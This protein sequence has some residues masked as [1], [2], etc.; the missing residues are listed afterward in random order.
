M[1]L[2]VGHIG[3][4]KEQPLAGSVLERWL[5]DA[6]FHGAR[7]VDEDLGELSRTA[8]ADLPPNTLEEVDDTGPDDVAPREI[9]NADIRVIEREGVG[10][11]WQSSTADEA[12]SGVRVDADHEEER[13]VVSVPERLETLL[14]N[15][16][17]GGTVHED[18][19]EQHDMASDTARL[20]V[21]DVEGVPRT[22]FC[23]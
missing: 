17:V 23:Q 13:Q 11:R 18:H 21:V 6:E 20:A 10:E 5:E 2:E 3:D 12:S 15:F 14:A 8:G 1:P 19:N 7:G 22:E 9:A 4:L 16:C